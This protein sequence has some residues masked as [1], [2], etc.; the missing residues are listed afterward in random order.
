MIKKVELPYC[1]LCMC[2]HEPCDMAVEAYKVYIRDGPKITLSQWSKW[3]RLQCRIEPEYE[4][5]PTYDLM[6][7]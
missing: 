2:H 6:H 3:K 4:E 1:D 5:V 7:C